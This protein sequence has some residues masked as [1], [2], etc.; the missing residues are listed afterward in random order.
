[1]QRFFLQFTT[2]QIL[3]LAPD[4]A[5]K[6]AGKDLCIPNK[7]VSKGANDQ[8]IWGECQ[9]SGNKPYQTQVDIASVAFKCSCP[10]R[11]FPC[12]HGI[13][14]LLLYTQEP[15][16]FTDNAPPEWVTE[17]LAKRID[18]VDKK[19]EQ[20]AK[21]A[22]EAA[23]T[24]RLLAREQL[25]EAGIHELL[26]W[27]KDMVRK[28][29]IHLPQNGSAGFDTMAKRLIDAKAPGVANMVTL[30][31]S[32]HFYKDGWES[33]FL[34]QLTQIYL[35]IAAFK[36]R[37][38]P[39]RLY[40]ADVRTQ[41]GFTQNQE[42]LK[43]QKGI[44]DHW[45]VLGKQTTE[46]DNVTTERNWL[47]GANS[48][49]Y[50][51]VLQ[52]SVRGQSAAFTLTPGQWI[53]AEL[54]YFASAVPL[55][56]II[57]N[58]IAS[59]YMVLP[60]GFVNWQDITAHLASQKTVLPF[61]IISPVIVQELTPVII[62]GEWFLQDISQAIMPIHQADSVIW[63]L[64]ALSGGKAL[65]MALLAYQYRFLPLGVW[66]NDSYTSL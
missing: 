33:Q 22:D 4:E 53:Q 65:Q 7:W 32:I 38:E 31:G 36:N 61:T 9:G 19:T 14:L 34:Q 59:N 58:Q 25:V 5:S 18:K 55:R 27:L 24:K 30:L 52:F 56:A 2:D 20:V 51:L 57:K 11:K 63:K 39:K 44:E 10:S 17:W 40:D 23:Q 62:N 54:V 48:R 12:K 15:T 16:I 64:L 66:I 49:Q 6:K 46:D 8:A 28:G 37:N 26:I 42:A 47:Y 43:A 29:I 41:I 3:A 60:T 45:L 21:P 35:A 1:L 50:A 13:G